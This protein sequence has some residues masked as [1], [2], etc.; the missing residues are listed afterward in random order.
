MLRWFDDNSIKNIDPNLIIDL[1][2]E[3]NIKIKAQLGKEYQIGYSYFMVQ[4][5]DNIK[6]NR[7]INYAIIPLIEQYYFGKEQKVQ[8]I[9]QLC[10]NVLERYPSP[11]VNV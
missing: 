11:K 9:K 7:I 10:S 2:N 6:L 5:L 1:L 3:I 8:E 4:N